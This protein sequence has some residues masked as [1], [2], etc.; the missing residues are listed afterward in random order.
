[1]KD[2]VATSSPYNCL[3]QTGKPVDWR[4]GNKYT[5]KLY[6]QIYKRDICK[7]RHVNKRIEAEINLWRYLLALILFTFF[8]FSAKTDSVKILT[9]YFVCPHSSFVWSFNAV[10]FHQPL[11]KGE[12]IYEETSVLNLL[13]GNI[14]TA[15][16]AN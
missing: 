6:L 14:P 7:T 16:A 9:K 15:K 3:S 2:L 4:R 1:M 5:R 13:R 11:S 12:N 10:S 8:F